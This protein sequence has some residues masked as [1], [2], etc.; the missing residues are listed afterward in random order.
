MT[1]NHL[2][3]MHSV[4][5]IYQSGTA[6]LYAANNLN[7]DIDEGEL[8]VIVGASGAGKTTLLNLLGGMDTASSGTIKVNNKII[9]SYSEKLLSKYRRNEIGFVFQFYN[10]ISNLTALENVEFSSSFAKN[11]LNP[12]KILRNIGLENKF[13][14]F[15]N[16]LS[17]GQQQRIAIARAIA[18]NPLLLLCDEPTGALDFKTS[19]EVLRLLA[20][21]NQ[22]ERK[23]VVIIT[24]NSVFANMADKV[25][26][27]KDG[28]IEKVY[29]NRHKVPVEDLQW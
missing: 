23:T 27:V 28:K 26:Q 9:S 13:D 11:P 12:R 14:S 15:P 10:L 25:I 1:T 6:K 4:C 8:V 29:L 20:D 7:F 21:F 19:K 22:N 3:E 16:E 5:K 24:H 18:K 2:I 17:G